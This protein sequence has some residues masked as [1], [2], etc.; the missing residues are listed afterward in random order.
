[1][2]ARLG[3]FASWVGLVALYDGGWLGAHSLSAR[4]APARLRAR[5]REL[6]RARRSLAEAGRGVLLV[7]GNVV[8]VTA[9]DLFVEDGSGETARVPR[10]EIVWLR[11]HTPRERDRVTLLGFADSEVD[12]TRAPT[13]PRRLPRRVVIRAAEFPVIAHVAT[14]E[15]PLTAR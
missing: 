14:L 9:V 5:L 6:A 7:D 13:G 12:P 3:P 1:V 2:L 11:R 15:M 8:A 4:T 10:A